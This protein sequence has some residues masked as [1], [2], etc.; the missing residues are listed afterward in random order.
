MI[1]A[2]QAKQDSKSIWDKIKDRNNIDS[3]NSNAPLKHNNTNSN[4]SD[5]H[6]NAISHFIV[7]FITSI[8]KYNA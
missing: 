6:N 7:I 1:Y 8:I 4:S 3:F 5:K 2:N